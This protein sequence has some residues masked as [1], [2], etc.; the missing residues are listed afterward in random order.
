[1]TGK[2]LRKLILTIALNILYSKI[3]NI[4]PP[5]ISKLDSKHE[6]QV[7]LLMISN[8]VGWHYIAV[9]KPSAYY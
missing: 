8:R 5:Y 7:I 9:T 6:K 4:Y 1:M 2:N 3:K